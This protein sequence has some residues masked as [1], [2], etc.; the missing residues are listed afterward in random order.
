MTAAALRTRRPSGSTQRR[1]APAAASR[2]VWPISRTVR[3]AAKSPSNKTNPSVCPRSGASTFSSFDYAACLVASSGR[4]HEYSACCG[5]SREK[6]TLGTAGS[7][8]SSHST[9][10]P[11]HSRSG[12]LLCCVVF[13]QL[14]HACSALIKCPPRQPKYEYPSETYHSRTDNL[15]QRP[16]ESKGKLVNI[17]ACSAAIVGT[18]HVTDS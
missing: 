16:Q 11:S 2:T 15:L 14:L 1:L 10:T 8:Y 17:V 4:S 5:S 6:L 7:A 18:L 9:P 12:S 3:A 13:G